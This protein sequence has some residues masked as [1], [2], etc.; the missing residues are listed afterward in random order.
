[1]KNWCRNNWSQW[2]EDRPAWFTSE[3][4]TWVPMDMRARTSIVKKDKRSVKRAGGGGGGGEIVRE[5]GEGDTRA[6]MARGSRRASAMLIGRVKGRRRLNNAILSPGSPLLSPGGGGKR[7]LGVNAKVAP[8][9]EE[10]EEAVGEKG[11][12]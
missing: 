4:I 8:I 1:M 3:F 10:D 7:K 5:G 12:L 2:V 11:G 9:L 6:I